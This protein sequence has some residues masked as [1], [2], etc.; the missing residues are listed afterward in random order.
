[1]GRGSVELGY[2]NFKF[3]DV[4]CR[5]IVFAAQRKKTRHYVLWEN[6]KTDEYINTMCVLCAV[7]AGGSSSY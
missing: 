5:N 4:V 7:M 3:I 1:M 6:N 2:L